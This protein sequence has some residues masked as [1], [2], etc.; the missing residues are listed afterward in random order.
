VTKQRVKKERIK[1]FRGERL[2]F[3]REQ[4]KLSQDALDELVGLGEDSTMR[5]ETGESDPSAAQIKALA[6]ALQVTTD[7]LLGITDNPEGYADRNRRNPRLVELEQMWES[8]RLDELAH[9]L[10]G[11]F[12]YNKAL[13]DR[14]DPKPDDKNSTSDA[15]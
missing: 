13:S 11:E 10:L 14:D 3:L 12:L 7:Y 1:V 4:M 2:K 5:Y 8:G 15:A 6:V 9:K